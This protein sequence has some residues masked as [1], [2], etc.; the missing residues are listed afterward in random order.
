MDRRKVDKSPKTWEE[1]SPK[2]VDKMSKEFFALMFFE[3]SWCNKGN[4]RHITTKQ[5]SSLVELWKRLGVIG[6]TCSKWG[7][8]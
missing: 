2:E 5:P 8:R 3:S 4:Q 1:T 6:G 7:L